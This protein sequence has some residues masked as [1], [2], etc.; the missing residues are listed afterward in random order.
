MKYVHT[1]S[2]EQYVC[3]EETFLLPETKWRGNAIDN[4][5]VG[6]WA[7]ARVPAKQGCASE[8]QGR[9]NDIDSECITCQCAHPELITCQYKSCN[10]TLTPYVKNIGQQMQSATTNESLQEKLCIAFQNAKSNVV[11][12]N[13]RPIKPHL[14]NAIEEIKLNQSL[15]FMPD[16]LLKEITRRCIKNAG[17]NPITSGGSKK[18]SV[19]VQDEAAVDRLLA[20][21][22]QIMSE[23]KDRIHHDVEL[24]MKQIGLQTLAEKQTVAKVVSKVDD[25]DDDFFVEEAPPLPTIIRHK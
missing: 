18:L 11:N 22:Q 12:S 17:S 16:Q 19:D 20:K 15:K 4:N 6:A 10:R 2:E 3:D 9:K 5:A 1:K 25:D 24:A 13:A 14:L 7:I 8:Y 23:V 21:H